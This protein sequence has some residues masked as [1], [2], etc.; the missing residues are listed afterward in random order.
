MSDSR[1]A[2]DQPRKKAEHIGLQAPVS[3]GADGDDER[4]DL[5]AVWDTI[6][7][8]KWAIL[9]TCVLITGLAAGITMML[10]KVYQATAVVSIEEKPAERGGNPMMMR[11]D[12]MRDLETEIGVLQ[13]SGELSRRVIDR[14]QAIADTTQDVAFTLLETNEDGTPLTPYE[15]LL[16]LQGMVEFESE[17]TQGLILLRVR[18][19]SAEEAALIAN[20]FVQEYRTFSREMARSGVVAAREFLEGQLEKRKADIRAIEQE[21][22][23]FA[24]SNAVATDGL[25]GQNVAAEYAELQT[26]RDRLTFELEQEKRTL[27]LFEEQLETVQPNLRQTV[28]EEQK[29]Q[30]LRTQIQ[31][32]ENQIAE[33]KA[34]SEQYYINDPSLRGNES[35]VRELADM[36][37]RIEGF[38]ARKV[39]LTEDLVEASRATT[40]NGTGGGAGNA[41]ANGGPSTSIG[42]LGTLRTRIQEQKITISR[43]EAQIQAIE[44]RIEGFEGRLANIPRQTIQREQLDRRLAQAEQ[45]YNDIAME[46]QR[47]IVTEESELGYVQIMRSAVIPMLPVSP[48][49]KQNILLGLLLGL[50]LGMGLAFVRESMNWQIYEPDD[51]QTQGYSLVGVIPKMDREIKKAFKGEETVEV[52]GH[53]LSTTLFPLLNPW[54]PITENYRL[55]R[56]NL[57]FAN[58]NGQENGAASRQLLMVTSPEPGDGKTTTAVNLGIAMALSGRSV[59]VIDADMR[60]SNVHRMLG[61]ERGPGLADVLTGAKPADCVKDTIV[62][63]LSCLTAGVPEVPPTEL[64]DTERMRALLKESTGRFDVVILDTPPVLAATDPVVV[65]PNCDAILV[66]ASADKTD[67]RALS[68]VKSTLQAVGVPIGGIIFNGYDA[69]KAS[70]AYKYGYGY[71]YKYDYTPV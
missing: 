23:A 58:T 3:P 28:L 27:A 53:Q 48:N 54:S 38:E 11:W 65:A 8:S 63:G 70:R 59:L 10:P 44:T 22:E 29:V 35:R 69:E 13:N 14:V 47:T 26:Q 52:E 2:L 33:L 43:I 20:V 57:Q 6:K 46:L 34:Q 5:A 17:P 51:I 60:R 31:A 9:A 55:V 42:Q 19:E 37:R 71:D 49:L 4:L 21:W 68:Q 15:E 18:S 32:L 66:V 62:D 12:G 16:R 61:L 40:A 30:S 7:R 25:D 41:E 1:N 67:F 36:K 64:L 39:E 56:A 24:Q 50:G 45:F